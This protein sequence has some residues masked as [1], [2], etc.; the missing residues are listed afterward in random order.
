MRL[1]QN[2]G[3]CCGS[4]RC[5]WKTTPRIAKVRSY[6]PVFI[7]VRETCGFGA[8]SVLHSNLGWQ[9]WGAWGSHMHSGRWSLGACRRVFLA[10]YGCIRFAT[11]HLGLL[12][13]LDCLVLLVLGFWFNKR[14]L[15][16]V[17]ILF[18]HLICERGNPI[19]SQCTFI[20]LNLPVDAISETRTVVVAH[21][22]RIWLVSFWSVRLIERWCC[23]LFWTSN[24][25]FG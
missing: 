24:N 10:I 22:D 9:K 25:L 19:S 21:K 15:L 5:L 4:S 18:D 12:A 11:F 1:I 2:W 6:H 7:T 3:S 8:R 14:A 17:K 13:R 23:G 16:K 20:V